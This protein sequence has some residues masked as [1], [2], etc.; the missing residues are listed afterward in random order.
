M[1]DPQTVLVLGLQKSGTSLLLRLLSDT[2]GFRNPVRFEGKEL[3]GDDPPFAPE[4]FPAGSFYQR[5]GGERGHELGAA[6]A[7]DEVAEHLRAELAEISKPGKAIVLKNPYNTVRAPWLRALFPEAQIVAVVRRP[8]PNVF[9]LLKKHAENPHVHRG[10]E[11]GG[12]WGVKPAGWRQLRSDDAVVQCARQWERVNAKL[13]ADRELIDRIVPY[14]ELCA[15]PERVVA[16]IAEALGRDVPKM[17]FPALSAQDDEHLRGGA[18][19]SANKVY[20]RTGS[21]DLA[22]AERASERL[23]PLTDAQRE[24]VLEICG[25]TAAELGLV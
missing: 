7:T 10:P 6:E 4:A 18:L 16:E 19:E 11:E 5:G 14:H 1:S 15:E 22:G 8:L 2:K 21:L 9:S 13:W 23:E 3:W 25:A 17:D 20:K 24:R 12:W